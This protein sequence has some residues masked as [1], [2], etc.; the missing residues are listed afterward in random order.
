M[1]LI[2]N[3]VVKIKAESGQTVITDSVNAFSWS[4]GTGSASLVNDGTYGYLWRITGGT[5]T[6]TLSGLGNWTDTTAKTTTIAMRFRITGRAAN[7]QKYTIFGQ[8]VNNGQFIGNAGT[9]T[10]NLRATLVLGGSP[11][12]NHALFAYTTGDV[13]TLVLRFQETGTTSDITSGWKNG[14]AGHPTPDATATNSVSSA[15]LALIYSEFGVASGETL[16]ILNFAAWNRGLTDSEAASVADDITQLWAAAGT[17]YTLSLDTGSY[18]LTGSSVLAQ[19]NV[20][21]GLGTGNYTLT[22]TDVTLITEGSYRLSLDSGVY[23][24]TGQTPNVGLSSLLESGTYT[25]VGNSV[26]LISSTEP[27][28]LSNGPATI[29]ISIRIGI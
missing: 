15:T 9:S 14:G 23:N 26:R 2:D 28:I 20:S 17:S 4:G 3:L 11:V 5:R 21:I 19:K 1:A 7:Y 16:D 6:A 22:G 8:S 25:V 18:T 24:I 27:I 12:T 29:S 10:G 13:I